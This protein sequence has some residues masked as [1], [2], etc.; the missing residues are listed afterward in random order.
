MS[1]SPLSLLA[2]GFVALAAHG[3][4]GCHSDQPPPPRYPVAA[5]NPN[6]LMVYYRLPFVGRWKILRTHYGAKQPDQT[7]ALDIVPDSSGG[8]HRTN[9]GFACYNQP[10][11]SPAPGIVVTVVDGVPENI[12]GQ[13][14]VYDQHGN[15][16]VIDHQNGEYTLIAHFIPGSFKVRPGQ[17][18]AAG[19]E[20][21]RCGNSGMSTLPHI[22][23]QVM[24]NA[25]PSIAKGIRQRLT[26]YLKSG[27]ASVDMPDG[28]E[29]VENK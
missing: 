24:D 3:L 26:T 6:A 29:T 17:V 23:W 12:P 8:D 4:T 11:L 18:I 28:K 10:V 27:A 7:W 13:K 15:Y 22:H 16:V 25:N 9:S 1:R 5:P 21:G 2:A 14:N 19:V 20:L